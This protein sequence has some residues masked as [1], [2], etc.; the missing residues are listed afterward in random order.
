[1]EEFFWKLLTA[2]LTAAVPVLTGFLCDWIHKM[3]ENAKAKARNERVRGLVEE[4]DESVRTAVQYVNQTFVDELKKSGVFGESDEYAKEAFDL[5]FNTTLQTISAEA[6]E[7]IYKTFGD[8]H[9]YL[10]PK[11]EKEVSVQKN[12]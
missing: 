1:M 11:I 3:A 2:V 10:E 4:I 7:W 9:A 6:A 12:W 5:A 8:V